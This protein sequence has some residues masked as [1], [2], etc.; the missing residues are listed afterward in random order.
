MKKFTIALFFV[1]LI[2]VAPVT[3]SAQTD[4]GP[5]PGSFWYGI[6]TT[7]ENINLFFTFNAEKKAEQALSYAERRLEQA[8]S[9]AESENIEAVETALTDYETKINLASESSKKIRNSER[10]E[11]L[12][13]SIADNTTKHQEVL[14]E[15]LEKVPEEARQ[16][17]S[18]AI[19]V[20]RRGQEEATR[21]IAELKGEVEKLK[22]EVAELKIKDEERKKVIEELSKQQS[23]SAEEK[24]EEQSYNSSP[25][26][27]SVLCN[28]KY[29][30]PTCP[31]GQKFYCPATG[32]AQCIIENTQTSSATSRLKICMEQMIKDM[33]AG[34]S[35]GRLSD[36]TG[37]SPSTSY[38]PSSTYS[39]P[40]PSGPSAFDEARSA[41]DKIEMERRLKDLEDAE[42]K[43]K[44]DCLSRGDSSCW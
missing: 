36:C 16:A 34:Y 38:P 40:T 15:V 14:S 33:K 6:T 8:T 32:D 42:F 13:T 5:T 31:A 4:T 44:V 9:A 22:Q 1:L 35:G 27:N 28:S 3:A 39:P 24:T 37:T 12:L 30:T 2:A 29:W 41:L 20:S 18:K 7:F 10:A 23:E 43:R 11:K 19:E 25:P 26:L 21:Q 17:I